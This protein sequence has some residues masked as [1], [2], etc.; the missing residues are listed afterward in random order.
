MT[1]TRPASIGTYRTKVTRVVASNRAW[2]GVTPAN[3]FLKK[4][5]KK[6]TTRPAVAAAR[7]PHPR[8]YSASSQSTEGS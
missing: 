5:A 7:S 1:F 2:D 4:P 3:A 8:E 6:P